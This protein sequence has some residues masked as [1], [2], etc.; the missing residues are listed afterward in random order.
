M[1]TQL[2]AIMLSAS[3]L[4]G[5]ASETGRHAAIAAL[6]IGTIAGAGVQGEL[7]ARQQQ[8]TQYQFTP[9][10][11]DEIVHEMNCD[12]MQRTNTVKAGC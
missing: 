4:S 6:V 3:L 10:S 8:Q 7:N 5:C 9:M 2:V 1:K 11:T 12:R